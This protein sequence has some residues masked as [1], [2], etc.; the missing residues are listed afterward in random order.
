MTDAF[1][2]GHKRFLNR[3]SK[4]VDTGILFYSCRIAIELTTCSFK[5][6]WSRI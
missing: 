1:D 3:Y 5:G 6:S 2:V 4:K